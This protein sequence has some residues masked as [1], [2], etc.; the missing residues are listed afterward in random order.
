MERLIRFT[1]IWNR[2]VWINPSMVV[3]VTEEKTGSE[4]KTTV[5]LLAGKEIVVAKGAQYVG[6]C[7]GASAGS[8]YLHL[9]D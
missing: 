3:R 6:E 2:E 1:D 9:A 8:D 7:L 5:T 4:Y